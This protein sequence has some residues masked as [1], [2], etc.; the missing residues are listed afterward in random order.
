MFD[1]AVKDVNASEHTDALTTTMFSGATESVG[2]ASPV[3]VVSVGVEEST[4]AA[5]VVETD[6]VVALTLELVVFVKEGLEEDCG[7]HEA[8]TAVITTIA[9]AD[10]SK[11]LVTM[12]DYAE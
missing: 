7:P 9:T 12:T 4:D 6:P 5:M 10:K 3:S 8:T 11:R 2:R 1:S